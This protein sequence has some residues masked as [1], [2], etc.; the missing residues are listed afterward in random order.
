LLFPI[1]AFV[2]IFHSFWLLLI[3]QYGGKCFMGVF[4]S[5]KVGKLRNVVPLSLFC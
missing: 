3:F 2:L 5:K 4:H 1:C